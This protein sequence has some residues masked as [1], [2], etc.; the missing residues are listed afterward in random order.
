M[1]KTILP[2][3]PQAVSDYCTQ[4][5]LLV[6]DLRLRPANERRGCSDSASVDWVWAG[7]P[8]RWRRPPRTLS[9]TFAFWSKHISADVWLT[10]TLRLDC[11]LPSELTRQTSFRHLSTAFCTVFTV[12]SGLTAESVRLASFT[13]DLLLTAAWSSLAARA[14]SDLR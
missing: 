14:E 3:L 10:L 1:L 7:P 6:D 11:M 8:G 12:S 4:A 2:S 9:R 5:D 13:D